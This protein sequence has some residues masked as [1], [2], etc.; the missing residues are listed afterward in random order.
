MKL[1]LSKNKLQQLP[2]DFGRLVN[3]QHLDLLNNRLVTLPVSFAQLKVTVHKPVFGA[4][5][6]RGPGDGQGTAVRVA[7]R[8]PTLVLPPWKSEACFRLLQLEGLEQ[9]LCPVSS[10]PEVA[11]PEG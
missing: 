8:D 2:A 5:R 1:D 6:G 3:L 10:E 7:R 9:P 11:G 4:R